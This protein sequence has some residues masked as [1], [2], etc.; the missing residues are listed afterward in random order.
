LVPI[1]I[2]YR[3]IRLPMNNT[4]LHPIS[5]RFQVIDLLRIIGRSLFFRLRVPLFNALV[6]GEPLNSGLR[7]PA[8]GLETSLYRM[9][10]IS[11]SYR[12]DHD[13]DRQT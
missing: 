2:P 8:K 4:N 7:N 12:L 1:E 11:I 13:C 5:H 10:F 3:P 9:R 6:R